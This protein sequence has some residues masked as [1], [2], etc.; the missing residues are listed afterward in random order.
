MTTLPRTLTTTYTTLTWSEDGRSVTKVR[1]P[2]HDARRRFRYEL[3]VNTLLRDRP[4][5]VP[6]PR[7]LDH[8]I[9]RRSLTFEAIG[10]E[11]V[12]P[13]YATELATEDL[14]AILT[15]TERLREF[16]PRRRWFRRLDSAQRLALAQRHGLL[17]TSQTAGLRAIARRAHT[18]YRFCHGDITARNVLRHADTGELTLIDWEWAGLYPDGYELAF[19]WYSLIDVPDGRERVEARV[20]RPDAF[21]LSALLITLWHLQW[22]LPGPFREKHLRTKDE[23][24]ERLGC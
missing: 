14:D 16:D 23:L 6:T 22:Y 2:A 12:G 10:A 8:D 5:P 7:L 21:L 3:K 11:P 4:P 24:V 18:R 19:L 15:L 13:K 9:G 17:T 20:A 1:D